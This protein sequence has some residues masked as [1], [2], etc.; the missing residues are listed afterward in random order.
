MSMRDNVCDRGIAGSIFIKVVQAVIFIIILSVFVFALSRLAPGDPMRSYYG[1]A[2]ERMSVEQVE[3]A[4]E[5][6]GLND[7]LIFQYFSWGKG[8][9]TGDWGMSY[10][11]KEPVADVVGDYWFNT[12]LLGGV[13][14]ILTFFFAILLG[15]F[16]ASMEGRFADKAIHKLGTLSSTIPT[17]FLSIVLIMIFAVKLDVLPSGGAAYL[18]G[19]GRVIHLILPCSVLILGHLWYYAYIIRNHMMQE[20]GK[21]YVALCRV[22][23]LSNGS[24]L[25]KHCLK[26]IL[27]TVIS[28]MAV[29]LPHIL[30]GT[31]IVE[32]VFSY[33]GLGSLSFESVKYHDYNMLLILCLITGAVVLVGNL[34]GEELSALADPRMRRRGEVI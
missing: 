29:S 23:G 9:L 16:C 12:L 10:R 4:R 27:P 24:I 20:L 28:L 11:Y 32:M 17:F 15:V 25:F 34:I 5:D 6:L 3:D 31:Y 21:D 30:A 18:D 1:D 22:K 2:I 26:N 8:V 13:S 19:G 7:P 33:P 14:F